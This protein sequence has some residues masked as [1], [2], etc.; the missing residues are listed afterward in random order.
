MKFNIK[1]PALE[2]VGHFDAVKGAQL[3]FNFHA[4]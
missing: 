3:W 4:E 1:A 2:D